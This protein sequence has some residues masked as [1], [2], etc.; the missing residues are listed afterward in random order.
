[1]VLLSILVPSVFERYG[2]AEAL[3]REL[4]RQAAATRDG[5]NV[6]VLWLVDNRQR[7]LGKKREAL[8]AQ[9]QGLYLCHLDDDDWVSRDFVHAVTEALLDNP[10]ADVVS[11]QSR[12]TLTLADEVA[13]FTVDTGLAHENE[14]ASKGEDG[15]WKD[16]KRKPWTWCTWRTELARRATCQDGSVDEDWFWL[17]QVLPHCH[18]E[19]HLPEVLHYYRFNFEATLC[20]P[21]P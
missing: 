14:Q 13:E 11:Y 18:V 21:A 17:Q 5:V 3:A 8:M 6:E 20:K 4:A 12:A 19:A 16:I 9:A 7:T 15:G 10:S 2:T 1:V